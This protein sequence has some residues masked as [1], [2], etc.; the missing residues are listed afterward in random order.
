[1]GADVRGAGCGRAR[2]RVVTHAATHRA[3]EAV[4]RIEAPK[5]IARAAR[6]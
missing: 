3:I 6:V 5:I 2:A 1:M 4:W